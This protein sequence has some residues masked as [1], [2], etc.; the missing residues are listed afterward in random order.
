MPPP[1]R[2]LP[3]PP[4]LS[5]T[6]AARTT[7]VSAVGVGAFNFAEA[8]ST[9]IEA[10]S[11]SNVANPLLQ[12]A[13]PWQ[14]VV[15]PSAGGQPGPFVVVTCRAG[16]RVCLFGQVFDVQGMNLVAATLDVRVRAFQVPAP[17]ETR[18]VLDQGF[19]LA[20]AGLYTTVPIPTYALTMRWDV[21]EAQ[22]AAVYVEL[23]SA[24][25]G[26]TVVGRYAWD[27][28]PSSGIPIGFCDEIRFYNGVG[29]GRTTFFLQV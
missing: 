8:K 3:Q 24:A 25:G 27:E 20:G 4:P 16:V 11:G 13:E 23:I 18:N 10:W 14:L 28:Q 9:I 29:S 17:F 26:G 15:S 22:K 2:A 5:V 12:N 21:P 6:L 1:R 19:E 7:P